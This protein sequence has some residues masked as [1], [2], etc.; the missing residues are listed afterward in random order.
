VFAR[1]EAWLG[2]GMKDAGESGVYRR[3]FEQ[4]GFGYWHIARTSE[5][6]FATQV[7]CEV[8]I[9]AERDGVEVVVRGRVLQQVLLRVQ[10]EVEHAEQARCERPA[11]LHHRE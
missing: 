5:Y 9:E 7:V 1:I 4:N 11:G 6:G 2:G 8:A 3:R 10:V